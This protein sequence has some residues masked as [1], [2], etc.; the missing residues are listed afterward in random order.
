MMMSSVQPIIDR[1][2]WHMRK[3]FD[4]MIRIPAPAILLAV[5]F[6]F[7]SCSLFDGNDRIDAEGFASAFM[8]SFYIEHS[9]GVIDTASEPLVPFD[10]TD[11][12]RSKATIP[13]YGLDTPYTFASL[14]SGGGTILA[15]YPERKQTTV[16]TVE[17]TAIEPPDG[18]AVYLVKAETTYPAEDI[19]Q[20]YSEWYYVKDID[21]HGDGTG[22]GVWDHHDPIVDATGLVDQ[23]AREKQEILF[24]DGSIRSETIVKMIYESDIEDGFAPFLID[25]SMEYPALFYPDTDP[26]AYYSSVVVYTHETSVDHDYWFWEGAETQDILG[27]RFYTEKYINGGAQFEKTLISFE[28]TISNYTTQGGDLVDQISAIFIGSQTASLAESVL[29][30]RIVYDVVDGVIDP[31]SEVR[32][33]RMKTHVVNITDYKDF[34]I[35]LLNDQAADLLDWEN[36]TSYIPDGNADEIAAV[37]PE[38][39]EYLVKTTVVNDDGIETI[40]LISIGPSDLAGLYVSIDEGMYSTPVDPEEDID[41]DGVVYEFSGSQGSTIDPAEDTSMFSPGYGDAGNDILSAGTVEAWIYLRA[42]P[43]WAGIVH[44]GELADCSDEAWSLQF[45]G[46]NGNVA[47]AV[48]QQNPYSYNYAQSSIRLNTGKWYYLA[49]TWDKATDKVIIYINGIKRG[50]A[51]LTL[52]NAPADLDSPIVVGS[53]LLNSDVTYG[54][55]GVDGQIDG[56]RIS[57]YAKTAAELK[58]FY[59]ENKDRKK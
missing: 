27:V 28:K 59:D 19:R 49:G 55:Y 39:N 54:Y 33:T 10:R 17:T 44:K 2:R 58:A 42:K 14:T 32:T 25:G 4:R 18:N 23:L 31:S 43:H 8:Q 30:Q 51:N 56:V 34:Q 1:T 52:A 41:G 45:W 6:G 35:E 38:E 37:S 9:A 47:F 20:A 12:S 57:D 24:R 46:T 7:F 40:E 3:V 36:A 15:D 50:E 5:L 13:V 22:I 29:R 26:S 11:F 16:F 48:V 53:Q 21:G